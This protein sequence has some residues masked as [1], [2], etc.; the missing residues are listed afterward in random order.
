MIRATPTTKENIPNRNHPEFSGWNGGTS[1]VGQDPGI[2]VRYVHDIWGTASPWSTVVPRAG[3]APYQVQAN[4]SVASCVGGG[5]LTPVGQSS[6]AP[7]GSY[8]SPA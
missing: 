4:W 7:N 6:N 5:A 1:V 3:S 2:Q 8:R